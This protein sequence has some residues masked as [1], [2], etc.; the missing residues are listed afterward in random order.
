M[1]QYKVTDFNYIT[2]GSKSKF[3]NLDLS[4]ID[5]NENKKNMTFICGIEYND[6]I[7]SYDKNHNKSSLYD[8]TTNNI[9]H[10]LYD[11]KDICFKSNIKKT[12]T[13]NSE[14]DSFKSENYVD[15]YGPQINSDP[16]GFVQ[17]NDYIYCLSKRTT[18]GCFFKKTTLSDSKNTDVIDSLYSWQLNSDNLK[19][20]TY[21]WKDNSG[22]LTPE[23]FKT[24]VILNNIKY[25]YMFEIPVNSEYQDFENGDIHSDIFQTKNVYDSYYSMNMISNHY[26]IDNC[27]NYCGIGKFDNTIY[28]KYY[29]NVQ[30]KGSWVS[31]KTDPFDGTI[32]TYNTNEN[33]MNSKD[34]FQKIETITSVNRFRSSVKHKSN[35]FS[36]DISNTNI[37]IN[38]ND[39]YVKKIKQDIKNNIREICKKITPV[40]TQLFDVYFNGV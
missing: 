39:S 19:T 2:S 8:N 30:Y 36:I 4:S 27:R 25:N 1:S 9:I 16:L 18:E 22:K 10:N 20:Y 15:I 7:M 3:I 31:N 29:D 38:N 6:T 17:V 40:N 35:L 21:Y 11:I 26:T 37:D 24:G 5:N 14:K 32:T 23:A 34:K 12:I 13:S 28:L 33:K